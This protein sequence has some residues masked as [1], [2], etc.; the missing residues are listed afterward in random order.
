[1]QK[2]FTEQERQGKVKKAPDQSYHLT[3]IGSQGERR[4]WATF[5]DAVFNVVYGR[6][7]RGSVMLQA[8]K[9]SL[10]LVHYKGQ[11]RGGG[12]KLDFHDQIDILWVLEDPGQP[13]KKKRGR[14]SLQSQDKPPGTFL[15]SNLDAHQL[16][17][18]C[19]SRSTSQN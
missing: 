7:V 19:Y 15:R 9:I 18:R 14:P 5:N 4:F 2:F 8:L 11:P 1:V 10:N 17:P 12:E 6:R 16:G 3:E 13:R